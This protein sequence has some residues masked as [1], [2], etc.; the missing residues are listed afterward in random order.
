[1]L[2]F[3]G[4]MNVGVF[5][6]VENEGIHFHQRTSIQISW[7]GGRGQSVC[8]CVSLDSMVGGLCYPPC[9]VC[10]CVCV[11]AQQSVHSVTLRASVCMCLL[12]TR[13]ALLQARPAN[14]KQLNPWEWDVKIIWDHSWLGILSG[15]KGSWVW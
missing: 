11:R 2:T 4:A 5:V 10:V 13:S 1:M 7:R 8:T 3:M 6:D 12:G 9:S 14:T 15:E